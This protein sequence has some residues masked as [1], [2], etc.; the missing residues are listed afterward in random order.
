M[1]VINSE[2]L[3][4]RYDLDWLRVLAFGLL[5]F[6]HTGMLYVEHWDFHFKSQYL[7]AALEYPMLLLSPLVTAASATARSTPALRSVERS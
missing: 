2:G 4:R 6:F 7:S 1:N 5:I 3:A